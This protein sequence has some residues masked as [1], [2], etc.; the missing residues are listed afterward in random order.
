MEQEKNKEKGL[1]IPQSIL[2]DTRLSPTEK[3]IAA[4]YMSYTKNG[5]GCYLTREK[6]A[7]L[8][9]VSLKTIDRTRDKLSDLKL[10]ETKG[11]YTRWVG[12][13]DT[14]SEEQADNERQNVSDEGQN[15]P[16]EVGQNVPDDGQNVTPPLDK[17]SHSDYDK[18]SHQTNNNKHNKN[19]INKTVY[20]TEVLKE[21]DCKELYNISDREERGR[22]LVEDSF[23][24]F[25]YSKRGKRWTTQDSK[26]WE[27]FRDEALNYNIPPQVLQEWERKVQEL[28]DYKP[29]EQDCPLPF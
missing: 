26:T 11:I 13:I 21:S 12:Q 24:K 2:D 15:D 29:E 6:M 17:M 16:P 18:L 20:N 27:T 22:R 9:H 19:T 23:R 5:K 3:L 1:W 25:Y 8:L 14:P 4:V 7:E 28:Q 10:I